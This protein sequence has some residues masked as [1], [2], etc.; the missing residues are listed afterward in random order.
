MR[1]PGVSLI[2]GMNRR[3]NEYGFQV[4]AGLRLRV[5]A[6]VIQAAH[7]PLKFLNRFTVGVVR[8]VAFIQAVTNPKPFQD[9]TGFRCDIRNECSLVAGGAAFLFRPRPQSEKKPG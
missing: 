8:I 7:A 9:F 1:I 3:R 5:D 2:L 4:G 6:L